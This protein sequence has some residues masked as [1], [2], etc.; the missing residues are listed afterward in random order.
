MSRKI[1][2]KAIVL[3]ALVAL[4]SALITGLL[5]NI[6]ERKAE[7]RRGP[8]R[9]VEVGEDDTDP[10]HWGI[11]WPRRPSSLRSNMLTSSPVRRALATAAS[12]RRRMALM[13]IA[14]NIGYSALRAVSGPPRPTH[15]P[16]PAVRWQWTQRT[17]SVSTIW[18]TK[19]L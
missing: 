18:W 4:A 17:A 2:Y 1:P 15:S 12:A 19:A 6:Y 7:A 16:W 3:L 14:R 11:N 5:V 13:G 10:A 9:L 8:V